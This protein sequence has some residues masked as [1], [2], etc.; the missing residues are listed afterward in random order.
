MA[1]QIARFP[2]TGITW[3]QHLMSAHLLSPGISLEAAQLLANKA[4]SV[5]RLTVSVRPWISP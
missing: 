1:A 3:E 4:Q 5:L 2:D